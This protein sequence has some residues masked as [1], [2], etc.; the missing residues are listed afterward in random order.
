M[1]SPPLNHSP[2]SILGFFFCFLRQK[3]FLNVDV[4]LYSLI[5]LIHLTHAAYFSSILPL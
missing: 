3:P 4:S 1:R 2:P 5:F